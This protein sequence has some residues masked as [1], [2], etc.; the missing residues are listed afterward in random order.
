MPRMHQ[1]CLKGTFFRPLYMY[2]ILGVIVSL[3]LMLTFNTSAL[4]H[5]V[6]WHTLREYKGI[7]D[8]AILNSTYPEYFLQDPNTKK[9]RIPRTLIMTWKDL[10]QVPDVVMSQWHDYN[11]D[12]RVDMYDDKRIVEF[13]KQEYNQSHVNFFNEIELLTNFSFLQ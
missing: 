11:P 8:M 7:T 5:F 12:F 9:K 6:G 2:F 3:S 13:L 10:D 1:A 4:L